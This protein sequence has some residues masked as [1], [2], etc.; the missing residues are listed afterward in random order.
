MAL[1]RGSSTFIC[2]RDLF[3]GGLAAL[4]AFAT[5]ISCAPKGG[6]KKAVDAVVTECVL[7]EGQQFSLQGR[8]ATLPIKISFK[9]DD[10]AASEVSEIQAGANTWNNF[11]GKSKGFSIF[12]VG[13]PGS[14]NISVANQVAPSCSSGTI[15][16]GTVIYK[17]FTWNKSA[18][19]I[20]VTTSCFSTGTPATNGLARIFN[21]ILEFNYVNF[22][23]DTTGR[24][25]DIQSI[26]VHE[27]GHLIGLDHSCGPLGK[28]NS[29]KPNVACPDPNASPDD[30]LVTS[31]MFRSVLF[32][33]DGAGE[34]K[35]DLQ[36]NDMGRANCLYQ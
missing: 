22:F 20:A 35:R 33:S 9:Q 31:V 2:S 6:T 36:E 21:S 4:A 8:W 5:A 18:T 25:P 29:S 28:P 7:P 23:V 19:A 13:A 26:A 10:W 27:L 1:A 12:D 34:T 24:F 16:D 17:R 11:F 30:P 14:G 3:Y 32:D 15:S